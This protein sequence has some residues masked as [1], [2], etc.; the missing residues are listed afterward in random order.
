MGKQSFAE[1][2]RQVFIEASESRLEAASL[3][4]LY[5]ALDL[6]SGEDRKPLRAVLRDFLKAGEIEC[7]GKHV[8][9][10][11]GKSGKP[12]IRDAMW[13]VI[14][15]RKTVTVTDLQELSGAGDGYAKEFLNLLI[16]RGVVE[17]IPA[18][19]DGET[20]YRLVNDTGRAAPENDEKAARLRAIRAA[21]KAAL[22][23]IETAGNDLIAATQK[24]M[25]ARIAVNDMPEVHNGDE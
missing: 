21:K 3:D 12:E 18:K 8:Y 23:L 13:R 20:V 25:A 6:V 19:R 5:F 15:M 4:F 17:K 11:R 7:V 10:Y 9:V 16:K 14:R 24:L 22:D 2:V 1:K